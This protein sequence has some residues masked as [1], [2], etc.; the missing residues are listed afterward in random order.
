MPQMACESDKGPWTRVIRLTT[1]QTAHEVKARKSVLTAN[2]R[3][4]ASFMQLA[5]RSLTDDERRVLGRILRSDFR[6]VT[7]LREQFES[8]RVI[9]RCD[10]GCPSVDLEPATGMPRSDQVGR[11]APVELDVMHESGE[12]PGQIILFIDDGKLSYLEYVY[13]SDAPPRVWPSDDHLSTIAP[14]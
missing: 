1:W 7:A 13:Y 6:G 5:P 9:G 4:N 12:P 10:C 11:L 3:C 8:V 14:R 2:G